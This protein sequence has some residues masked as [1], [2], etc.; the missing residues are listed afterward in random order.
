MR[1][2]RNVLTIF[3][4]GLAVFAF[5]PAGTPGQTK[6]E[7]SAPAST[8]SRDTA[9]GIIQ[10]QIDLSRT[11]ENDSKRIDLTLRAADLLWPHE[12][13]QARATFTETFDLANRL[14]KEKGDAETREGNL[15]VQ[16]ID[17]RYRVITAIAKRDAAWGR[18]LSQQIL[19]DEARDA[20]EKTKEK[21]KDTAE[22][23]RTAEKLLTAASNVVETNSAT[24]LDFANRSLGYAASLQLP[25]FLYK[26]AATDRKLAD[27]FYLQALN[28]YAHAP[29]D[30]FL[31]LSSYPFAANR[32]IGEMPS[33]S[34][35][36]VPTGFAP[37]PT[38]Q[39]AFVSALLGRAGEL[40]QNPAAAQPSRRFSE[41]T[42]F[43]GRAG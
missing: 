28:A 40:I 36:P 38:L 9:L 35:Y 43:F 27:Q 17:Y 29:M 32:E 7:A 8:C 41:A 26:L 30:Q 37:N 39:R 22:S 10:R 12:Q 20:A 23:V 34:Y 11:I 24:A 42:K 31:Y 16:G 2:S 19:D 6:T 4:L 33:Y 1:I 13:N 21:D 5:D 14:Y 18:K 15:R 25:W 3:A